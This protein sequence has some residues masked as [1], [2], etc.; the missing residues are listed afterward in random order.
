GQSTS[1]RP[2]VVR[3]LLKAEAREKDNWRKNVLVCRL[4]SA[5]FMLVR[6]LL[7]PPG[8]G[9]IARLVHTA[10]RW[11][12]RR[13]RAGLVRRL[14]AARV[15]KDGLE[16][17]DERAAMWAWLALS[18]D[19]A[20]R[21]RN[22]NFVL[23]RMRPRWANSAAD[24]FGTD[25]H[26]AE[27]ADTAM[28]VV[29]LARSGLTMRS[30]AMRS[31]VDCLVARPPRSIAESAWTFMAL[32]ATFS[33]DDHESRQL[34][35]EV[36]ICSHDARQQD[37]DRTPAGLLASA[38]DLQ[39][40]LKTQLLESQRSDGG[41]SAGRTDRRPIRWLA[42]SQVGLTAL[43]LQA[44]GAAGYRVGSPGVDRA[45]DFLK[46]VQLA[47]GRFADRVHHGSTPLVSTNAVETTANALAALIGVGVSCQAATCQAATDWLV[48]HQQP[49]G[50]W[51]ELPQLDPKY[52]PG[53]G[54][55]CVEATAAVVDSLVAAGLAGQEE[56][57]HAVD[58]LLDADCPAGLQQQCRVLRALC[59]WA[60]DE[61]NKTRG[62][63]R[64]PV[65]PLRVAGGVDV[66]A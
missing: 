14:R 29:A 54:P 43:V 49:E 61:N 65:P 34:P 59:H 1:G 17:L 22:R 28:A 52:I 37:V 51:G 12:T 53:E 13:L 55:V 9:T 11:R 15:E 36:Q 46:R 66:P 32:N 41:W 16:R 3:E 8:S 7:R 27:T 39:Q 44:L 48:A 64:L 19:S 4:G 26:V 31:A 10:H 40:R 2:G 63:R 33:S 58:F 5:G 18:C 21:I 42:S 24:G 25:L 47:D 30:A 20:G 45:V 57:G 56:V 50:G 35:P 62:A 23:R 38:H 6:R 60:A